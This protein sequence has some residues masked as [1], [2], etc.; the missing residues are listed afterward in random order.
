MESLWFDVSEMTFRNLTFS[1]QT[2]RGTVVPLHGTHL[3]I[4]LIFD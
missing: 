3:S 2:A 4:H 1:L